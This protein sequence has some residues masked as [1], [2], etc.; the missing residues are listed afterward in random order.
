MLGLA[1]ALLA[2]RLYLA[3]HD[4]AESGADVSGVFDETL[5]LVITQC[6]VLLGVAT[7]VYLLAPPTE[8]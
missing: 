6:G 4:V 7:A 5:D 1:G 8:D 3:I 2:L